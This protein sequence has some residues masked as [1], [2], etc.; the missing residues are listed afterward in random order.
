MKTF[1]TGELRVSDRPGELE[2]Y[3]TCN[4]H[5]YPLLHLL[6]FV[7]VLLYIKHRKWLC[8]GNDDVFVVVNIVDSILHLVYGTSYCLYV[9]VTLHINNI[10][11]ELYYSN[12]FQ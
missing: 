6:S 5:I 12:S 10:S 11:A 8:T 3:H 9:S 4:I 2:C 7:L 1:S